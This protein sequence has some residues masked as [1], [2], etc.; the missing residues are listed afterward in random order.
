[1][2]DR[3]SAT[4][5]I[6]RR[7]QQLRTARGMSLRGLAQVAGI[8]P[9]YLSQAERGLTNVSIGRMLDIANALR[10]PVEAL[11]GDRHSGT[12]LVTTR[13]DRPV[14]S[15]EHGCRKT[16]ITR[17]PGSPMEVYSAVL[18]VG[19][20][21]GVSPYVH[22]D[23]HEVL[24]VLR[25]DVV[26]QLGRQLYRMTEGDSAEFRSS[27]PHRLENA[28]RTEAE[29]LWIVGTPSGFIEYVDDLDG[30]TERRGPA[31]RS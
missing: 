4:R 22:G 27:T 17:D 6:G 23:Q 30:V 14:L 18:D 26:F 10:V 8:S 13:A 21:T 29:V 1:M 25:G 24:L 2:N 31:R 5:R 12:P 7:I 11:L 16:L 3:R 20:T 15:E 28:G 19:G 9:S